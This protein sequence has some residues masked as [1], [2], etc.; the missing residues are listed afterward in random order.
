MPS[1]FRSH[2]AKAD[3]GEMLMRV[4]KSGQHRVA[5]QIDDARVLADKLVCAIV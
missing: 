1:R 5:L 2:L 3:T 4:G